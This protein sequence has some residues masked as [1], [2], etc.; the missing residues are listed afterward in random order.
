[1]NQNIDR[2]WFRAISE[3]IYS[4]SGIRLH[5]D[6][7]TIYERRVQA[8]AIEESVPDLRDY[9]LRLRYHPFAR[10]ITQSLIEKITTG[11]TYFYRE[12]RQLDFFVETL[13]PEIMHTCRNA[14]RPAQLWNAGCSTGEEPYT[15]AMMLLDHGLSSDD[16][17]VLGGDINYHALDVARK[18][19]YRESSFRTLPVD[20]ADHYFTPLPD[21]R[22][23]LIDRVA[24]L[25]ELTWMNITDF[26]MLNLLPQP[27]VIFCR[28]VLIYFDRK[29]K[30]KA[31]DNFY[32]CLR[33]GGLLL[34]GHAESLLN[35]EHR[36]RIEQTNGEIVYRKPLS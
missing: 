24:S 9:Y 15:V 33:P 22:Q 21:G 6:N 29:A 32:R 5:G 34:L 17:N 10:Q 11:E 30:T 28:N 36:F 7:R 1:M 12:S 16:I 31:I 23:Q 2:V 26:D 35:L 4:Q 14:G 25:V 8:H 18:R 20:W 27:D 3:H 19:I 13:M